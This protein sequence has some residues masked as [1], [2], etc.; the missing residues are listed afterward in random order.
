MCRGVF[1]VLNW[2]HDFQPTPDMF[3][4]Y[5]YQTSFL[6]KSIFP[7]IAEKKIPNIWHCVLLFFVALNT[8][9][10]S[11]LCSPGPPSAPRD[12]S[13]FR[14]HS[15]GRL[16]LSWT[17]P[18]DTGGRNDITYSVECQH[19]DGVVCQPCGER[20]RYEPGSTKLTEARVSVS[21]LEAH[22][23]YTFIVQAHSGVSQLASEAQRPPS[24][25]NVT[26]FLHYTGECS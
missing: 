8:V 18:E 1:M 20:V 26:I 13:A 10:I 21:E 5:F 7:V 22:L 12:L 6:K 3:K 4:S 16:I 14:Q 24:R 19:C 15:V 23:N 11:N 9:C 25:S 17:P 2:Q